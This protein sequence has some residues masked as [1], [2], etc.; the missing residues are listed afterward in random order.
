MSRRALIFCTLLLLSRSWAGIARRVS[1]G[2][3]ATEKEN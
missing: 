2:A 3:K 1:W